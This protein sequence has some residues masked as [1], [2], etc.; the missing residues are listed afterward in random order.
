MCIHSHLASI[1]LSSGDIVEEI[2]IVSLD[3][4]WPSFALPSLIYVL[5]CYPEIEIFVLYYCHTFGQPVFLWNPKTVC[6][7][8]VCSHVSTTYGCCCWYN[9][10]HQTHLEFPWFSAEPWIPFWIVWMTNM[11]YHHRS[12][13][14]LSA[15]PS[16]LHKAE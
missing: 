1:K 10:R 15:L 8:F 2:P 12:W 5:I 4:I 16:R 7:S 13:L 6:L 14:L 9:H 11:K 3:G